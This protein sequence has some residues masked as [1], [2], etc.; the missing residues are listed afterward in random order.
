M[1]NTIKYCVFWSFG[2]IF[3]LTLGLFGLTFWRYYDS[4]KL[5]RLE[6][7]EKINQFYN[8][9]CRD[10]TPDLEEIRKL[11][12]EYQHEIL[13][14]PGLYAFFDALDDLNLCMGRK[15]QQ[16]SIFSRL[17]A[18]VQTFFGLLSIAIFFTIFI[19]IYFY[20]KL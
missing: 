8:E 4:N 12:H 17:V 18:P 2:I 5:C 15:C 19:T 13:E 6:R 11:C 9:N 7:F 1:A 10:N 20:F 3:L 14:D 16:T